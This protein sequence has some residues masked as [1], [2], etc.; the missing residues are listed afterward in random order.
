[1][2]GNTA[3]A[4]EPTSCCC[5]HRFRVTEQQPRSTTQQP[6]SKHYLPHAAHH[7]HFGWAPPTPQREGGKLHTKEYAFCYG[8]A[9]QHNQRVHNTHMAITTRR[10]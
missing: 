3:P 8:L 6:L 1:M 9:N 2:G 7:S 5:Y 10:P 4:N